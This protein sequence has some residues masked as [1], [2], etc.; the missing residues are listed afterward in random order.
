MHAG[1]CG[2]DSSEWQINPIKRIQNKA[3][4]SERSDFHLFH[5]ILFSVCGAYDRRIPLMC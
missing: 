3:C 5:L 1:F 4:S 2:Q